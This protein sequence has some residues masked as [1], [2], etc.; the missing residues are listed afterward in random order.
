MTTQHFPSTLVRA[1][2]A[3][4]D[5]GGPRVI[6]TGA[7]SDAHT[8]NLVYLQLLMQEN[9]ATVTNLGACVPPREVVAACHGC[10]PDV[11]VM[12]SVNGH[13]GIDGERMIRMLRAEFDHTQ[14]PAVIGGKLGV[15]GAAGATSISAAL[16]EAGFNAVF[17]DS[18]LEEFVDYIRLSAPT[19]PR[20]LGVGM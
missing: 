9:G 19:P 1:G 15:A 16:R 12:S 4:T 7:E 18:D 11:L 8:W 17:E 2:G 5:R 6:L 3:V 10:P 20:A 14:I 13:G